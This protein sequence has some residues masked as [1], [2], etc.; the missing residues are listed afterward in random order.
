MNIDLTRE[1]ISAISEDCEG[2]LE[3]IHLPQN[4]CDDVAKCPL[5]HFRESGNSG[6]D[7]E[8]E[9]NMRQGLIAKL[10]AAVRTKE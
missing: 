1:E 6:D 8:R 2:I 10:D 3:G 5:E 9:V 4:D 7:L